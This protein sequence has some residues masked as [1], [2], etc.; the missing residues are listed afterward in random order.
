MSTKPRR[1]RFKQVLGAH[2]RRVYNFCFRMTLDQ[3]RAAS[4]VEEVFLRAYVGELPDDAEVE[5]WLIH[6]A[7]HVLEQRLP[8]TPEVDF[9]L[10]DETLRSEATR[11]DVVRSLTDPQRDFML[12]ELKQGC[13]TSV[14]NCLS[15]GE[16]AA[17][18]ASQ[19]MRMSDDDAAKAL[20][21][22]PAAY[23]VRLSRARKKIGDYLAPRCEHVNPM[24]PCR[25]PARVGVA[26]RKGFIRSQGVVQLRQS[27]TPYGRYGTGPDA[28]DQPQRDVAAIFGNLPDPDLPEGFEAQLTASVDNGQWERIRDKKHGR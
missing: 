7:N 14:I 17:F 25:C 5:I 9:D 21:V 6:I 24:N 1:D 20:G 27:S 8:R 3:T 15:P 26:L 10:L 4:C 16:R 19:V 22:T 13:M 18:T 23:K 12:W 2:L 28:D 11:T